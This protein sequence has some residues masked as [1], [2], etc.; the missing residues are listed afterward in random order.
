MKTEGVLVCLSASEWRNLCACG[1]TPL[2][3]ARAVWYRGEVDES[4]VCRCLSAAPS[5]KLDS[6]FEYLIVDIR[7][8]WPSGS[9]LRRGHSGI[10]VVELVDVLS[11]YALSS[12]ARSYYSGQVERSSIALADRVLE[13]EWTC[14]VNEERRE[15]ARSGG[16]RLLRKLCG[17]PSVPVGPTKASI[18]DAIDAGLGLYGLDTEGGVGIKSIAHRSNS[19]VFDA[20]DVRGFGAFYLAI[21]ILWICGFEDQDPRDDGQV[22]QILVRALESTDQIPWAQGFDFWEILSD[23]FR[24]LNDRYPEIFNN[25]VSAFTIGIIVRVL[26]ERRGNTLDPEALTEMLRHAL[27][28]ESDS[29]ALL[30]YLTAAALGPERIWQL[31][32]L[33]VPRVEQESQQLGVTATAP[34]HREVNESEAETAPTT[35]AAEAGCSENLD[36]GQQAAN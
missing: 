7:S 19:L 8:D 4:V 33:A 28:Y 15:Q 16:F 21:A 3:I 30:C 31:L 29:G 34:C 10:A 36:L 11:H 6:P 13:G 12:D 26:T 20:A 5:A 2:V 23:S 22:G 27:S 25:G 35:T 1:E 14:W 17:V 9:R 32:N 24:A 18:D